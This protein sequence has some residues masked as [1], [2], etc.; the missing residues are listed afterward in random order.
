MIS[1]VVS[2]SLRLSPPGSMFQACSNFPRCRFV[3]DA[4][5]TG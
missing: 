5:I 2:P 1:V 4:L 3:V